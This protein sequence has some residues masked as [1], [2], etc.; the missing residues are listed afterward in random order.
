M[1]TLFIGFQ[2]LVILSEI[3]LALGLLFFL[4]VTVRAFDL[5][6][7]RVNLYSYLFRSDKARVPFLT[8]WLTSC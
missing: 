1:V 2:E 4:I 7:Y 8:F 6:V 5:Q 3:F